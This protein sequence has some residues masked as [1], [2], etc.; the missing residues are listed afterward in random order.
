MK[1]YSLKWKMEKKDNG[2]DIKEYLSEQSLSRRALS[3]IKFAGGSIKVNG[4]EQTVRFRLQ[5]F[6]VLEIVFPPEE[7]NDQMKG[8]NIPLSIVYE[9]QDIIIIDKPPFM[10]S[11]PSREH[12]S[13]SLANALVHYYEQTNVLAAVHIVTR[14]DRNTSGLVLAAKHRH[15]HHLLS[16][17]QQKQSLY[18]FYEALAEGVFEKQSGCIDAP[19]GRS[20][21]SIIE[22]QVRS[23]GQRAVTHFNVVNQ[24]SQF[25][26]LKLQLETGRTHQIRV[27]M[28][29][30]GHPLLGDD[31]YGGNQGEIGR[32]ALHCKELRFTHP[33]KKTEM[34]FYASL[35]IDMKSILEKG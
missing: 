19:I 28:A 12:P 34:V 5:E 7:L 14:L 1:P 2:K 6:D 20:P 22:R 8:E 11:I 21:D 25:T 4:K 33:F 15:A 16:V 13:G 9:D 35:P 29:H 23:D 27:H 31:L 3:D 24:L 32:Q 26:H 10:N 18:R 30:V 17:M